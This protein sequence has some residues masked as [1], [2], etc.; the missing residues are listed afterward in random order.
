MQQRKKQSAFIVDKPCDLHLILVQFC[1]TQLRIIDQWRKVLTNIQQGE[2]SD[3]HIRNCI[4]QELN[5]EPQCK[6]LF[7]TRSS[8]VPFISFIGG[9]LK[10]IGFDCGQPIQVITLPKLITIIPD[11]VS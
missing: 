5:R 7:D 3:S 8:A 9:W 6:S 4:I 2:L 10:N 1:K 11:G